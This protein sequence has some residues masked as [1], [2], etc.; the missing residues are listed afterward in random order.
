MTKSVVTTHV[1][2]KDLMTIHVLG[3]R[4][5]VLRLVM[6]SWDEGEFGVDFTVLAKDTS[7][8]FKSTVIFFPFHTIHAVADEH[9]VEYDDTAPIPATD[10]T[11]S[12]PK[13]DA[14]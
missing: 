3:T 9:V 1:G 5:E 12:T 10:G 4:L 14:T 6:S 13:L 7:G 2:L 11:S 8:I